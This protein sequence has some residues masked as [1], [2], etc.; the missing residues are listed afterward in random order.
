L[1]KGRV[2]IRH[3]QALKEALPLSAYPFIYNIFFTIMLA[4][5][6]YHAIATLKDEDSNFPLLFAHAVVE[7]LLAALAFFLDP[8]FLKRVFCKKPA[9]EFTATEIM[10]ANHIYVDV[11]SNRI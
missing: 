9:T 4:N 10:P 6:V 3:H 11:S 7:S 5:C 2:A 8:N 1:Y